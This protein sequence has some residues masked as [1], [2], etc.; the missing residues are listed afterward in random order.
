MDKV[1]E[2]PVDAMEQIMDEW[3]NIHRKDNFM[4]KWTSL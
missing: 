4:N 2:N 1:K 3:A